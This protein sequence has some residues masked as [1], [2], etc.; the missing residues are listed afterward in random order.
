MSIYH[1]LYDILNSGKS[2]VLVTILNKSC[3]SPREC[4]TKM[5]VKEDFSILGTI[6]GGIF[7][8]MSIKL[9]REV[10]ES[11]TYIIKSF[12]QDDIC[13]AGMAVSLKYVDASDEKILEYFNKVRE[14]SELQKKFIMSTKF[15]KNMQISREALFEEDYFRL[16]DISRVEISDSGFSKA[17]FRII[18]RD[19][20]ISV[21]CPML[22][23]ESVFIFGAG[24]IGQKLAQIT[25][26]LDFNT[27]ILD[28]RREFANRERFPEADSIIVLD[29]FSNIKNYINIEKNSFVIIVTRGHTD[30]QEVLGEVLRS[31]ARY[32]GMIG[33]KK[34]R[35]AT[36]AELNRRGFLREELD[37]VHSPI[38][39]DIKAETPEE[40]TISIA[41]EL[42]KVRREV[43]E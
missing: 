21:Y 37:K 6:G 29:S 33:S 20:G 8:A 11:R 2:I 10:F 27:V 39:I 32:I 41:A 9:A 17:K 25:K 1:Q 5:I 3:S 16:D 38:G 43:H 14:Y 19:D 23:V 18:Q 35:D 4:G 40:I 13:G 34:K 28:E 12:A 15:M 42:V 7:E 22:N 26:M 36:Y 31:N 30:D 24:H